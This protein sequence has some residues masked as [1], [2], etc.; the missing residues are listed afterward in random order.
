MP[1]IP[2]VQLRQPMDPQTAVPNLLCDNARTTVDPTRDSA[3][4][5]GEHEGSHCDNFGEG[6]ST[7]MLAIDG[8]LAN[9]FQL[10]LTKFSSK[11]GPTKVHE[12]LTNFLH[13]LEV[14]DLPKERWMIVVKMQLIGN[15]NQ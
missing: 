6:D 13:Q 10:K 15:A 9:I 11:E 1:P 2:F 5:D 8:T 14:A 4:T 7:S 3:E 12:W